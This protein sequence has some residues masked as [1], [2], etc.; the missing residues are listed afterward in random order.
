MQKPS[1][2]GAEGTK[3]WKSSVDPWNE[4]VANPSR[5]RTHS[6]PKDPTASHPHVWGDQQRIQQLHQQKDTPGSK[7]LASFLQELGLLRY[8]SL[9]IAADIDLEKLRCLSLEDLTK[10]GV[11]L[12][13]RRKIWAKLQS[14]YIN[15]LLNNAEHF[16]DGESGAGAWEEETWGEYKEEDGWVQGIDPALKEDLDLVNGEIETWETDTQ[17]QQIEID[18]PRKDEGDNVDNM[19]R[20]VVIPNTI[21]T[22]ENTTA[23]NTTNDPSLPQSRPRRPNRPLALVVRRKPSDTVSVSPVHPAEAMDPDGS[24]LLPIPEN[25]PLLPQLQQRPRGQTMS[26]LG[27][28]DD[29]YTNVTSLSKDTPTSTARRRMSDDPE[30]NGGD[31]AASLVRRQSKEMA[32]EDKKKMLEG[33]ASM[34]EASLAL[35]QRSTPAA[36]RAREASGIDRKSTRLNSSHT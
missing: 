7:E 33:L 26:M 20:P 13:P 18:Q 19:D 6:L 25:A 24:L 27:S 34:P 30:S 4:A 3:P 32:R 22:T 35:R 36:L 28:K 11:K 2:V 29:S 23:T 5:V 31:G 1:E 16:D 8:L 15:D 12:G 21:I 10:L 9:F 17:Q 14:D